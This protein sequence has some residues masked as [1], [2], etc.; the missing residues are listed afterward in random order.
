MPAKSKSQQRFFG[1]VDAYKKGEMKNPSKEVKNAAD[2]MT[3]KEVEDF[4]ETKHKGLPEKVKESKGCCKKSIRMTESDLHK[5]IK[6]SV[7][8]VLNEEYV[9]WC[10][11]TSEHEKR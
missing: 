8:R 6:E 2:S 11:R 10:E 4:A 9:R 7:K 5:I 1:M 3:R